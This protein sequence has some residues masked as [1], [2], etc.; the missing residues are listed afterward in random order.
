MVLKLGCRGRGKKHN[1]SG[2][3]CGISPTSSWHAL[4]NLPIADLITPQG[5]GIVRMYITWC[6]GVHI[7]S[8]DCPFI[9]QRLRKLRPRSLY[10]GIARE[11]DSAPHG[12]PKS[13]V[14]YLLVAAVL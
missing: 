3:V 2:E 8:V 6:N 9:A 13:E 4:Q 14:A 12:P 11:R 1:S 10:C 7:D 5:R